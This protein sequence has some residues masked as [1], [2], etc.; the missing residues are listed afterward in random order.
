MLYKPEEETPC[1]ATVRNPGGIHRRRHH[2]H[3]RRFHR[4]REPKVVETQQ[5]QAPMRH[6]SFDLCGL[7]NVAFSQR[8]FPAS[9][10][11][12]F[13]LPFPGL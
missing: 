6:Y 1:E 8:L 11:L 13:S 10:C 2:G 12:T 5:K 3:H 7:L 9:S 4:R